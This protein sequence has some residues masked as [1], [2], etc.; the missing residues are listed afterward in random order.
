MTPDQKLI[1]AINERRSIRRFRPEPVARTAVERILAAATRAPSAHNRQPWRFAILDDE[2]SKQRLAKAMGERLRADRAADGDA[3]DVI[4]TDVARSYARITGAPLVIVAF[5]DARVMDRY[6]DRRRSEAEY[7]MA[8]Q[9]TAMAV[10]NLLLAAQSEGLGA[11]VMCAPLFCPDTVADALDV[12][13]EW[14][15]QMLVLIGAAASGGN[16]R[17]RLTPDKV[18]IWVSGDRTVP[19]EPGDQT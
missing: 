18:A 13:R 14:K 19:T 4:D 2:A 12:P 3:M 10:Q 1:A 9:S 15:A 8:V 16:E 17:P 11:S 6:P 7:L 5:A